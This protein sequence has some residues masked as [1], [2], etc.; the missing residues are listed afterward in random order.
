[1]DHPVFVGK[2][3]RWNLART[4]Q[5]VWRKKR[6][7]LNRSQDKLTTAGELSQNKQTTSDK[8]VSDIINKSFNNKSTGKQQKAVTN[9]LCDKLETSSV[10]G[11]I[12]ETNANDHIGDVTTNDKKVPEKDTL[13]HQ[14][15]NDTN[16]KVKSSK[17]KKIKSEASNI[18]NRVKSN[19]QTNANSLDNKKNLKEASS[20]KSNEVEKIANKVVLSKDLDTESDSDVTI[21]SETKASDKDY[22]DS[23]IDHKKGSN[24]LVEHPYGALNGN[25]NE[26]NADIVQT[27]RDANTIDKLSNREAQINGSLIDVQ[28]LPDLVS[29]ITDTGNVDNTPIKAV[30]A[31]EDINAKPVNDESN[32]ATKQVEKSIEGVNEII[33]DHHVNGMLSAVDDIDDN[34]DFDDDEDDMS[35]G[36]TSPNYVHNLLKPVHMSDS[37]LDEIQVINII[38]CWRVLLQ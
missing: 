7:R 14:K 5:S 6:R 15:V 21:I 16:S 26:L 34:D 33:K 20:V 36:G 8:D 19:N 11:L 29:A 17:D 38:N 3:P 12:L 25:T 31:T 37:D 23:A 10:E 18:N 32:A 13:R 35:G 22:E 30:F 28:P 4:P 2:K 27:D 24:T 1:M 9:N